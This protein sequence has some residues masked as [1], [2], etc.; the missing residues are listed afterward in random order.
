MDNTIIELPKELFAPGSSAAYSGTFTMLEL[1]SGPDTYAFAAPLAWSAQVTNT[2][3]V[4][5]KD[6]V[7]L[8]FSAPYTPGGIEKSATEL[9]TFAKTDLLQPGASETVTQIGR[10]HV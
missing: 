10:A 3:D 2:G 6:V 1:L 9:A 8:Y 7:E 5:G 4:A